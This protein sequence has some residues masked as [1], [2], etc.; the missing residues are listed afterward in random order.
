MGERIFISYRRD[1]SRGYAGRLQ[2]DLS[3]RFA[4]DAVYRDVET[5]PG[6]D[7]G[8]HITSLVDQCSVV[9]AIIG[10]GW[11]EARDRDGRRRLDDPGDWVRV[12]LERA[13][14]REDVE[15]IPVLVDGAVI[16]RPEEL[17]PALA[18]LCRRNAF[19]LSDRRWAYDVEQL[20]SHLDDNLYGTSA[21]RRLATVPVDRTRTAVLAGAATALLSAFPADLI[22]R[23]TVH[24]RALSGDFNAVSDFVLEK[25]IVFGIVGA[26]AAL[27]VGVLSR[28]SRE[29]FVSCVLGTGA[30]I[31]AGAVYAGA[32]AGGYLG[33][34]TTTA[35][36]TAIGMVAAG[37][38]LGWAFAAD[39]PGSRVEASCG[40]LA[41][42]LVAAAIVGLLHA[43]V[44]DDGGHRLLTGLGAASIVAVAASV[45]LRM[46]RAAH[47]AGVLKPVRAAP[48]A[49]NR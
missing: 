1:D 48:P 38:F 16:P 34:G 29:P 10:P 13:L 21:V 28:R 24:R 25:V 5:P 12:E 49:F 3:R 22:A 46:P 44:T 19:E 32:Y 31:A 41:G 20:A 17:P 23:G 26:L 42:G 37:A 33:A 27:V 2:S 35:S 11:L 7:F 8:K 14:V 43:S 30:G 39:R 9:L 6:V 15:V 45:G 18:A 4:D 36:S 40:G 47:Y